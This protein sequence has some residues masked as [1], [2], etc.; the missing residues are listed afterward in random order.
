[1]FLRSLGEWAE[2]ASADA[3]AGSRGLELPVTDKEQGKF[4][5]EMR[6]A[7]SNAKTKGWVSIAKGQLSRA[8]T[9]SEDSTAK[10]LGDLAAL[11]DKAVAAYKK[12]KLIKTM[13][14]TPLPSLPA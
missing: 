2:R 11:D 7:Q 12:R 1:M 4:G 8:A 3:R 13:F 5:K 9:V 10:D 6:I 14:A